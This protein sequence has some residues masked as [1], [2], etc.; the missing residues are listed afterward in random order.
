MKNNNK[1]SL[2]KSSK[3]KFAGLNLDSSS[4]SE[5]EIVEKKI[6][7]PTVTEKRTSPVVVKNSEPLEKTEEKFRDIAPLKTEKIAPE[8]KTI[9]HK[10]S[11]DGYKKKII[12][13]KLLFEKNE[14]IDYGDHLYLSS[15]WDVWCHKKSLTDWSKDS[16]DH[17]YQ[18]TSIG[19]FF[20]F[21]NNFN[22]LDKI[23]ND[24]F[25]M[26]DKILPIWEDNSNRNGGICSILLNS[27]YDKKNKSDIGSEV[28]LS[29][30]MLI[31]NGLLIKNNDKINGI[32]YSVRA[33]STVL[34]KIWYNDFNFD[35]FHQLPLSFFEF[36]EKK[37]NSN[38]R[39][40][41][42]GK[43]ISIQCTKIKPEN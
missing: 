17:I 33:R 31:M 1:S 12:H 42:G 40:E 24:F 18:I 25:I 14:D 5:E 19:T 41:S 27:T 37:I 13:E 10:F 9:N 20:R 35:I 43:H 11:S 7:L 6:T 8:W 2:T 38:F 23:N 29:I 15:R 21:F 30:C 39:A 22:N 26:R 16:Y 4:E 34:I 32:S 36:F 3:N 28:A